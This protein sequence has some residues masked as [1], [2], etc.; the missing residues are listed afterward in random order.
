MKNLRIKK[1]QIYYKEFR[2]KTTTSPSCI[3]TPVDKL[4]LFAKSKLNSINQNNM[5]HDG[6][7]TTEDRNKMEQLQHI[8]SSLNELQKTIRSDDEKTLEGIRKL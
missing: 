4:L 2:D 8:I 3:S 5:L 1:L 6:A 7:I